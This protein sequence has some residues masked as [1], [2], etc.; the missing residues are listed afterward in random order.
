MAPPEDAGKA[1]SNRKF[2]LSKSLHRLPSQSVPDRLKSNKDDDDQEDVT[3]PPKSI[4][5]QDLPYMNRSIFSM[6]AA[7]G[8][9]S[10]FHSRFDD[11][12]DSDG[13]EATKTP[14]VDS[15]LRK[16]AARYKPARGDQ[17]T[18]LSQP[19]PEESEQQTQSPS[20][21]G[22]IH[23]TS[24]S[25]SLP[26]STASMSRWKPSTS[27]GKQPSDITDP[28]TDENEN[29]PLPPAQETE[30]TTPRSAPVLSRMIEAQTRFDTSALSSEEHAHLEKEEYGQ[31]SELEKSTTLLSIRLKDIFGFEG[32]ERVIAEYPCW[33]MQSI[34][35]QGYMYVTEKHICF[36]AYLPQKSN[37]AIKS[38]YLSKR[39]RNNPK[40]NRYWF[41]LKG[42]V[43]SY[44]ADP[45]NLY[46]PSGHIDLRYGISASISEN[47]KDKEGRDFTVTTD[48]RSYI[49]RA[50]S[51]T[52]AKEWVKALQKVIFRS[53]NEG[54]RVKI[55]LP[56]E[57]VIDIEQSPM[58][59]LAETF[60]IRVVDIYE[61]Y[62]IDEVCF[63]PLKGFRALLTLNSTSFRFLITVKMHSTY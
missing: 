53:Q 29:P 1:R 63:S 61:T 54:G 47:P 46:F 8:S 38:G 36:Y 12:S 51:A 32:P 24:S 11:S 4:G 5:G 44:F 6:I 39:G 9:R 27:K 62:A 59:D 19:I 17:G 52:S 20:D 31:S 45:S 25:K 34:A 13:G 56:L 14:R 22:K 2:S 43:L 26:R 48:H 18:S 41:S 58:M 23:R 33:L 28:S 55:S 49:F 60:K 35:L 37:T 3:A 50:D 15:S 30:S 40:Y 21:E 57:N 16:Q 7:A 42:D 10:D